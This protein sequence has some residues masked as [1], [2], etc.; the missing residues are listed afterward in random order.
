M[1]DQPISGAYG[2]IALGGAAFSAF[3]MLAAAFVLIWQATQVASYIWSLF[4]R[5][6]RPSSR[7]MK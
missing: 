3:G 2:L 1:I 7:P 5:L 6:P 4:R